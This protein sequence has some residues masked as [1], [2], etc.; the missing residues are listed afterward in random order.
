MTAVGVSKIARDITVQKRIE[1]DAGRLAAIV[2]S[3]DDS[4]ISKDLN[5]TI[6]FSWNHAAKKMFGFRPAE[7]NGQ[8]I[9]MIIPEDR[10]RRRTAAHSQRK[11]HPSFRNSPA[12]EGR[13]AGFRIDDRVAH[14]QHGR[15]GDRRLTERTRHRRAATDQ[16]QR[17]PV[18]GD[19]W[20]E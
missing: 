10:S 13:H 8:S 5:G 1:Q 2:E 7:A 14:S 17:K 18:G 20:V 19:C 3:S 6:L 9:R 16:Q 12:P 4:I 11:M 15:H